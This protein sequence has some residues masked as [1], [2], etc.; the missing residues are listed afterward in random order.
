M[1]A[2]SSAG[3]PFAPT[4]AID[5]PVDELALRLLRY[6]FE[7]AE[8]G[9]GV[10]RNNLLLSSTWSEGPVAAPPPDEFMFAIAEAFDWLQA[11]SLI[12]QTPRNMGAYSDAFFRTRLGDDVLA[13]GQPVEHVRGAAQLMV[14]LHPRIDSR[15]RAQYLLGEHEAAVFLAMREV[16]IRVRELARAGEED[17]GMSLMRSA[18]KPNPPGPLADSSLP[19]A[20]RQATMELFSDAYGVFRNPSGHREVEYA[21]PANVSRIVLLADLLLHLL[22]RIED[23][24]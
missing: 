18:F 6:R 17:S 7:S 9:G 16:E 15:V 13:S 12:A 21:D 3:N 4:E 10:S 20:E 19:A 22:D 14:G 23:T 1:A 2:M 8:S 5:L 11:N 24:R